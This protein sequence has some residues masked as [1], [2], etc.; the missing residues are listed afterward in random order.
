MIFSLSVQYLSYWYEKYIITSINRQG[1]DPLIILTWQA[2]ITQ[3]FCLQTPCPGSSQSP[4]FSITSSSASSSWPTTGG[5][6]PLSLPSSAPSSF[7]WD[8]SLGWWFT[9]E[10]VTKK[11]RER[12][13]LFFS[14][15]QINNIVVTQ[16]IS[17]LSS[18]SIYDLPSNPVYLSVED[19]DNN[20]GK[21]EGHDSGVQL[22]YRVLGHQAQSCLYILS[23]IQ[24]NYYSNFLFIVN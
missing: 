5:L 15:E 24:L 3:T 19:Q 17:A 11:W 9:V 18:H 22:I 23:W 14:W 16:I 6:S 7:Q 12:Q 2:L 13:G 21:I 1:L 8:F 10:F 4:P 20:E